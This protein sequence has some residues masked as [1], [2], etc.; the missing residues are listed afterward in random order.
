M[1]QDTEQGPLNSRGLPRLEEVVILPRGSD[2][3]VEI[4]RLEGVNQRKS[5]AEG[6][7]AH[8][9]QGKGG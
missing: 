3:S 5:R 7:A 9:S 2:D 4:L 1:L 8:S 6:R